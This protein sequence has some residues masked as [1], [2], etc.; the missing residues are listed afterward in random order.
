MLDGFIPLRPDHRKLNSKIAFYGYPT[1]SY[2][3]DSK[4]GKK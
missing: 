4:E 2:L 3:I 1:S